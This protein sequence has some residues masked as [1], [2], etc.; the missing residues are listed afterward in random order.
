MTTWADVTE[1]TEYVQPGYVNL[2][3][4]TPSWDLGDEISSGTWTSAAAASTTWTE[5]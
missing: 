4:V 1:N 3:Y 5:Q 2:G